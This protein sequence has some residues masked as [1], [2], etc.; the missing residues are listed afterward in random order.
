MVV[1]GAERAK[2]LAEI[3]KLLPHSGFAVVVQCHAD[4]PALDMLSPVSSLPVS[5][6]RGRVRLERDQV[7]LIPH[8]CDARFQRD[9]LIVVPGIYPRAPIDKLLRS[10]AAEPR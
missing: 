3:V 9:E 5:E 2:S 4:E 6:A 8:E 10:L 7:F 1:I